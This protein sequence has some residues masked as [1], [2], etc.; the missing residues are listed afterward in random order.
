MSRIQRSSQFFTAPQC[1]C[2]A[3][4]CY[5]T[6][7]AASSKSAIA[8]TVKYSCTTQPSLQHLA[9]AAVVATYCAD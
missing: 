7:T 3:Y 6:A 8:V 1:H 9:L 5:T 2:T 4:R